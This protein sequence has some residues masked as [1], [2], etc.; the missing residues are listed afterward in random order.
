METCSI[1]NTYSSLEGHQLRFDS[2]HYWSTYKND[3]LQAD[4]ED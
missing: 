2:R 4:A 1:P 3:T